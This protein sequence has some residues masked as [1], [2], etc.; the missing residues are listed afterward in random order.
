[1]GIGMRRRFAMCLAV[2]LAVGAGLAGQGL[3]DL[4]VV[5]AAR[6]NDTAGVQR[7]IRA[8][9]PV[10]VP[11]ADGSTALLAAAAHTNAAMARALLRAG[12]K[13][14]TANRYGVN[15]LLQASRVG[16]TAMVELLLN[17]GADPKLSHPDGETPLM[18]AA[19]AGRADAVRLLLA[20]GAEVNAQESTQSQTAL[21]WAAG[22]GHLDVVSALLEAGAR[23]NVVAEATGLASR[24]HADHPTGGLTA[25]MFAARQGHLDVARRL[26]EAGADTSVTN[27]D[28]ATALIIA[29][30][31]DRFDLAAMLIDK[32]ADVNDGSLYHAVDLHN[33]TRDV[34]MNDPTRPRLDHENELTALDLVRRL[35]AKGA[36][37]LKAVRH[38]FHVLGNCCA[39]VAQ[40]TALFHAAER[41]DVE[42]LKLFVA[43]G[44]KVD[45]PAD[46]EAG[47][48]GAGLT[49]LMA[50]M[51]GGPGGRG[52]GPGDNRGGGPDYREPANRSP[53]DATRVLLD[54]GA[55][56]NR[57]KGNGE[58]PMH[59]AAQAGNVAIM[60]LLADRGAKLDV[61]AGP[62][63]LTPLD[64]AMGKAPQ[65]PGRL[66]GPP[67][68]P[69]RPRVEAAALLRQLLGLPAEPAPASA[70][71]T[72]QPSNA[73]EN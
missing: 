2:L 25:L 17:A 70:P 18:A 27:P 58:T 72:P 47:G 66:G 65:A 50:A 42:A 19:M 41:A 32:G 54:A 14:D 68:G 33:L 24:R 62:Q 13:P 10:N 71:Q 20:R 35:V 44:V 60:Q 73:Q 1:M 53:L 69:A 28:G 6:K 39:P 48:G 29:I 59:V 31:N 26:V 56:P 4:R 55:D 16:D 45:P 12:A 21:M 57:A 7:L 52:G 36:D 3:G 23:P 34:L 43:A 67:P 5:Q 11:E 63:E 30:L 9:A 51:T 61:K 22:E 15:P 46:D 49:P 37:P 8:G 64:Y 38:Q 40:G